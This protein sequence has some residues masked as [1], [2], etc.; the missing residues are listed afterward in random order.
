MVKGL[1]QFHR[2]YY[3]QIDIDRVCGDNAVFN[4]IFSNIAAASASIH[5]F[6]EVF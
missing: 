6:L 3:H 4:R 2:F 1:I 5:V